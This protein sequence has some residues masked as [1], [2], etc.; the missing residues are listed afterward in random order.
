MAQPS[1][2]PGQWLGRQVIGPATGMR[3]Y[4]AYDIQLGVASALLWLNPAGLGRATGGAANG[5][6]PAGSPAP[7]SGA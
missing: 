2:P 5:D 1:V 6:T 4:E 3:F 7:C